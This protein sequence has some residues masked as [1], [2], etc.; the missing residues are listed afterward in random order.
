MIYTMKKRFAK[1]PIR[2]G[3]LAYRVIPRGRPWEI[4]I[5]NINSPQVIWRLKGLMAVC[6][7]ALDIAD[8][9][10]KYFALIKQ[11][12]NH[13]GLVSKSNLERE[14]EIAWKKLAEAKLL[15]GNTWH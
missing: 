1:L 4:L 15:L 6:F 12:I 10:S 5:V 14:I 2:S 11:M 13:Q 7:I 9:R 3:E 8:S